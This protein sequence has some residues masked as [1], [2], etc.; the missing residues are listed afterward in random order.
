MNLGHGFGTYLLPCVTFG[1]QVSRSSSPSAPPGAPQAAINGADADLCCANDLLP[2]LT[3]SVRREAPQQ[4]L[5]VHAPRSLAKAAV[6]V[7]SWMVCL[8]CLVS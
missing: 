1:R 4:L 7:L 3:V 8:M 2:K 5:N 6:E